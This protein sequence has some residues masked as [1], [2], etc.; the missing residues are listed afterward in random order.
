[1]K[2]TAIIN[3]LEINGWLRFKPGVSGK[4]RAKQI[5]VRKGRLFSGTET[6]FTPE[7][8]VH[9]IELHGERGDP[10]LYFDPNIEPGNKVIAVTGKL[11]LFGQPKTPWVRLTQNAKKGDKKIC[12]EKI[13]KW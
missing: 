12:V 3:R 10:T 6:E 8:T 13:E 7:G 5:F 4:L 2:C 1:M 11:E 9:T